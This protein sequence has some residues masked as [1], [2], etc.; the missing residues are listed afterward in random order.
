[1]YMSNGTAVREECG[2][3]VSSALL[4]EPSIGCVCNAV[5]LRSCDSSF[6]AASVWLRRRSFGREESV[7]L[8]VLFSNSAAVSVNPRVQYLFP[9]L[10]AIGMFDRVL[11]ELSAAMCFANAVDFLMK[12]WGN[13]G[14]ENAVRRYGC[15]NF[16]GLGSWSVRK[17]A[18]D[19]DP[20]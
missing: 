18:Q 2:F 14:S 7:I 3:H 20:A 17:R 6:N 12:K 1:M 5:F 8:A 15:Y 13:V 9:F 19:T 16:C 4:F 10:Y 11:A